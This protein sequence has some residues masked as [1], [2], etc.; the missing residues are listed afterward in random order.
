MGVFCPSEL[1]ISAADEVPIGWAGIQV[2]AR[3]TPPANQQWQ[4]WTVHEV[5]T[6]RIPHRSA[7]W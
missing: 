5:D 4:K 3:Q 7:N 1:T 2:R 6:Y